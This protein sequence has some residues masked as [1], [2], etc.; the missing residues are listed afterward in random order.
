Q[1]LSEEAVALIERIRTSEPSRKV[2]SGRLNVV[3]KY[4]SCKMGFT[5]Q[6]ES[7]RVEL[8]YVIELE[9]NDDVLEYYDQP[10]PI[11]LQYE[12]VTGRKVT[13]N[14]TPDFFVIRSNNAGW[15]E[16]KPEEELLRLK[17]ESPNRYALDENGNWRCPP[18]E[19]YAA[20]WNLTYTLFSSKSINY[21]Y[22]RNLTLL[23]DYWKF[24]HI[25]IDP[26][27]YMIAVTLITAKPGITLLEAIN[28]LHEVSVDDWYV[29]ILTGDIYVNLS[30]YPLVEA[31]KVKLYAGKYASAL[32]PPD[33]KP[34]GKSRPIEPEYGLKI[35][36][37]GNRYMILN[38]GASSITLK[39][40]VDGSV[41]PLQNVIFEDL[42][43]QGEIRATGTISKSVLPEEAQSIL[44]SAGVSQIKKANQ[45]AASIERY[46]TTKKKPQY[47][48]DRTLRRWVKSYREAEQ[49]WGSGYIGLIPK[50]SGS[51]A[52][53]LPLDVQNLMAEI[54]KED[55]ADLRQKRIYASYATFSNRC[56][57]RGMD[58]PCYKTF[59]KAIK[60]KMST[61]ERE[62]ARRGRRAAYNCEEFIWYLNCD[63]PRHGD[64]PWELVHIDHTELDI[65]LVHSKKR[66]KNLGR[67]WATFMVDAYSRRLLA[68]YLSF[69][70]PSYRSI[71]MV[72][73][74]CV[75]LH[76]RLPQTIV[77]D[78]GKEFHSIYFEKLLAFYGITKKSRPPA[79]SRFSSV[80]ERLFG[81]TNTA[82]V[83]NLTG[84]TQ[85][86][87][88]PRIAT[89]S[90]N[91]KNLAIWD[92]GRL[93]TRLQNWAYVEY[94]IREH[95]SL[96]ECKW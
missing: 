5:V 57:E 3:G 48:K 76:S 50:K 62:K 30:E 96:G 51:P 74:E 14:H 77:V 28:T 59:A 49:K 10:F 12:A 84:N 17:E 94:D 58:A 20:K 60:E 38:V 68:T 46:L 31:D 1:K 33:T 67:P 69:D 29:L 70:P 82:F 21:T 61:Y 83:H 4:P 71:M 85:I 75:R 52:S 89:K 8:P 23:E 15:V 18:G 27:I 19:V 55:F 24:D 63:Q 11:K 43:K 26:K 36:W 56:V 78:N 80:C 34:L 13:V 41:I 32:K 87:K 92:I 16:C 45:R 25:N 73:R 40:E 90:V 88:D 9:K 6:F 93:Y 37:D 72:M 91:P 86:M 81:T 42:V 22:Q 64:R 95:S 35:D 7:H 65:E 47:V 39:S 2:K 54:I 44:M 66:N 79:K 53:K